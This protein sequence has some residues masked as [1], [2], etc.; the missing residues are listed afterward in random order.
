MTNGNTP[1]A[2]PA[3]WYQDP[4]GQG[5]ARYW[6]G[7]SWTQAIDR[8]G[9][10]SNVPIDPSIAQQ[11]PVPGTQVQLP[12]PPTNYEVEDSSG[13]SSGGGGFIIALIIG[14]ILLVVV[15]VVVN[16]NDSSDESPPGTG[17]VPATDA[18]APATEAPADTG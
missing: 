3:G 6:N 17:D 8:G 4:T 10:Q 7:A 9:Q 14:L 5:D 11:P 16:N 1:P 2:T 18:P 15:I 13:G 12:P